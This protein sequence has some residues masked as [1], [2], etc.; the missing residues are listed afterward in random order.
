MPN[1]VLVFIFRKKFY[2][3]FVQGPQSDAEAA[4]AASRAG[5]AQWLVT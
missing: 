3:V 5:R 2:E 4:R 1:S